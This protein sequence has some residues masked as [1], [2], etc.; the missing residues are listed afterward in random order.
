MVRPLA[1]G[2]IFAI[3]GSGGVVCTVRFGLQG[4]R[5]AGVQR[6]RLHALD[7]QNHTP[8]SLFHDRFSTLKIKV[9]VYAR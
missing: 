7:L 5:K 6:P 2:V 4:I 9:L 1:F 3:H 8:A